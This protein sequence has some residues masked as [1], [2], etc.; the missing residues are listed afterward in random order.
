MDI[1]HKLPNTTL[2]LPGTPWVLTQL[3]GSAGTLSEV[4]VPEDLRFFWNTVVLASYAT[5]LNVKHRGVMGI[6]QSNWEEPPWGE[7]KREEEKDKRQKDFFLAKRGQNFM[8]EMSLLISY[9]L[10]CFYGQFSVKRTETSSNR[11]PKV[12]RER[13]GRSGAS[14]SAQAMLDLGQVM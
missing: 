7:K 3:S 1:L 12:E 4:M 13:K 11:F 6:P 10:Y 2:A 14:R 8:V 5:E 9:H